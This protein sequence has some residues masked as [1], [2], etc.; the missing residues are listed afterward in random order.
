MSNGPHWVCRNCIGEEAMKT[1]LEYTIGLIGSGTCEICD[2]RFPQPQ[3]AF[4]SHADFVAA[5]E[6]SRQFVVRCPL[7]IPSSTTIVFRNQ[8]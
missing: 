4:V 5:K 6:R 3:L 2:E 8:E 1:L 7:D